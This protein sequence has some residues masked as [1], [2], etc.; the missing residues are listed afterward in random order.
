MTIV[1]SL[2][3]SRPRILVGCPTANV[4]NDSIRAY[5][6]GLENLTY[7]Q[8]DVVLE[9]NSPT[10]EYAEKLQWLG[11]KFREKRPECGF[12]VIHSGHVSPR[13][14]ERIVH[15]RNILREIVLREKYDYFFS[16]EQDVVCPPNTIERLLAHHNEVVGG[17]YYNKVVLDGK[18]RKTP[19]LMMYPDDESKNI[20]KAE[21]VGFTV[22]FPSRL[23]E[24]AS[25]GLGCVL[26]SRSTL[27]KVSFQIVKDKAAFDDMHFA[28]DLHRNRVACYADT[29]ILCEHFYN[30]SFKHIPDEKF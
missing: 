23:V 3:T 8:F 4:K 10:P 11:E 30:E 19:V 29:S 15:G 26:I 21:W 14:R 25:I 28:L 22:L 20:G 13:V 24:V 1:M 7:Q 2:S 27:E 12:R 6:K 16:L 9:D 18:E 5:M 17:V